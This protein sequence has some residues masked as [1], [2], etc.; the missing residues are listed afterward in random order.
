MSKHNEN[1]TVEIAV[2]GLVLVAE[3]V[4]GLYRQVLGKIYS[5]L[6]FFLQPVMKK[7]KNRE[8]KT[9][10]IISTDA[11]I[12]IVS[13]II[14]TSAVFDSLWLIIVSVNQD[15]LVHF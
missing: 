11:I 10:K 14:R 5:H 1:Q 12:T 4:D 3:I 6:L 7:R 9:E 8:R 2:D 15:I 13:A